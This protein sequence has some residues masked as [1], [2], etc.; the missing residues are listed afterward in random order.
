LLNKLQEMLGQTTFE[1]LLAVF[2]WALGGRAADSQSVWDV[3]RS[4]FYERLRETLESLGRRASTPENPP[5]AVSLSP[6]IIGRVVE[7]V[8]TRP[9]VTAE[10]LAAE[11]K[12]QDGTQV[13]AA[14]LQA[15]LT[16]A[17]RATYHASAFLRRPAQARRVSEEE[18]LRGG[19][20]R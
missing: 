14:D 5:P 17:S 10:E 7:V 2:V 11:L 6:A 15:D 3:H 4:R 20:T 1:D 13:A 16:H 19:Y 12:A 9:G 18:R 8:V